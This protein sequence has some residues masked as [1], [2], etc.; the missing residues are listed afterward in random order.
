MSREAAYDLVQPAA[1]RAWEEKRPFRE[2]VAGDAA[3]MEHLSPEEVELA[4]DLSYHLRR[5]DFIFERAGLGR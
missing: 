4:F 3:L 2:I 1:M 5:I